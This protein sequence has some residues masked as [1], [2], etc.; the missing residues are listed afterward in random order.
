LM[1]ELVTRPVV[2]VI[3]STYRFFY[4][5]LK[6]L[7]SPGTYLLWI[8][9]GLIMIPFFVK[10]IYYQY[11]NPHAYH[12]MPLVRKAVMG[13]IFITAWLLLGYANFLRFVPPA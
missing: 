4:D 8:V 3:N 2:R 13:T 9:G 7:D 12:P 5:S 6:F 1:L 11:A 10:S